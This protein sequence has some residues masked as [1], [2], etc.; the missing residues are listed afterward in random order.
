MILLL[1]FLCYFSYFLR[2]IEKWEER[3]IPVLRISSF[4]FNMN[5][6]NVIFFLA[7]NI[8]YNSSLISS[9]LSISEST[10]SKDQVQTSF[11]DAKIEPIQS[12]RRLPKS[13]VNQ[14]ILP[15]YFG[16]SSIMPLNQ[17]QIFDCIINRGQNQG[18]RSLLTPL[19]PID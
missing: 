15:T 17:I 1:Q 13:N 8:S 19:Y 14:A 3:N 16:R 4:S 12:H 5:N 6:F 9:F 11:D 18:V 7:S 2:A 10:P